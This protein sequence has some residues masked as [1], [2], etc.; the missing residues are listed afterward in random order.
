MILIE[1]CKSDADFHIPEHSGAVGQIGHHVNGYMVIF[2]RDSCHIHCIICVV[3]HKCEIVCKRHRRVPV[4]R[5][6]AGELRYKS[7]ELCP[8]PFTAFMF[9]SFY[10]LD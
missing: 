10:L 3:A 8:L 4:L 5:F 7:V 6:H 9:S 1:Y 2:D